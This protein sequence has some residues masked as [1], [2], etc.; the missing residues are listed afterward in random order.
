[1]YAFMVLNYKFS[2]HT[3]GICAGF[4]HHSAETDMDVNNSLNVGLV[5][6]RYWNEGTV[7]LQFRSI[8]DSN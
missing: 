1:M 4:Q 7:D 8:T 3:G 5:T 2:D 6:L